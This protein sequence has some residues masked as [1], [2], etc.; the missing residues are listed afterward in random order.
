[1]SSVYF[2]RWILLPTGEI[3]VNGGI[4]VDGNRIAAIGSRGRIRRSSGERIVNLGETL[5]L[6]GFVNMHTHLE[7]EVLRGIGREHQETFTSWLTKRSARLRGFAPN[8]VI[9]RVRLAIRESLAN[10]ITSV[11]DTT[12]TDI[13]PLVLRDE[14]IRSWPVFEVAPADESAE[15]KVVA[16]L[17]RR[18]A[19]TRPGGRPGIAPYALFS[20]A[21]KAHKKVIEAAKAQRYLWATHMA[22]SSEELQAFSERAGDLFFSI[23]RKREWHYD[24]SR[25]GPMHTAITGNLIPNH[26]ICYHCNYVS[27]QELSLLAA[28][29]VTVVVCPQYTEM[30]G[31]KPFPLDVALNRRINICLGTE[32][33]T[34]TR[35]LNLFDELYAIRRAY[36]HLQAR[37]LID[38]VTRNPARALGCSDCLGTL[39]EGKLADMI[40][41][42]FSHEPRGDLLEEMLESEPEV[43]FVMVDGEEVIEGY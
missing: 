36:P 2:A 31:H 38:W 8:A 23:T 39:E 4:A 15:K 29:H 12:R 35:P 43:V 1:M 6:P 25:H 14:P 40:G 9:S 32:S 19:R 13:P 42:R 11:V 16:E 28:K 37:Q 5:L 10:G 7:E 34:S 20:L 41:V 30:Q 26:A 22:E 33:S 18:M 24:H 27:G 3:L 21:P 17:E